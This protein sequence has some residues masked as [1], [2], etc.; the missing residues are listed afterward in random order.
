MKPPCRC[1]KKAAWKRTK[2]KTD[3]KFRQDQRL[4]NQKWAQNNPGYWSRYRK[5]HPEK[6]EKNRILQKIRNK[7]RNL[8]RQRCAGNDPVLI[9]KVD[10]SKSK[11]ISMVGQFWLVPM[12]AKVDAL[13]VNIVEIPEPYR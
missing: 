10:A 9:A 7:R 3:P 11:N 6:A 13:K 1:A 12:I 4:S 8:K 2:M 5:R